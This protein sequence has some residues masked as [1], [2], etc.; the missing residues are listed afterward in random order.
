MVKGIVCYK[1]KTEAQG[2]TLDK[3]D[4]F[5][6]RSCERAEIKKA[7]DA[8]MKKQ[9]KAEESKLNAH[10]KKYKNCTCKTCKAVRK[11]RGIPEP[12]VKK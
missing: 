2:G 12:N 9:V 6:C 10:M 8:E 11:Q 5:I 3:K 1:C 7:R 4:K